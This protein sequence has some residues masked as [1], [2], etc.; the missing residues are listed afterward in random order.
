VRITPLSYH[1]RSLLVRAPTT[2]ASA[3]GVGL[4][5]FV[6]AAVLMLLGGLR[7]A[8]AVGGD[9]RRVIVLREGSESELTSQFEVGAAQAARSAPEVEAAAAEVVVTVTLER[10]DGGGVANVIL[11]GVDEASAGLRPERRVLFDVGGGSAP[12]VLVG[13]AIFGR[14]RGLTEYGKAD[15]GE[16]L[17]TVDVAGVFASQ[18]SATESELWADRDF[19]QRVA[20]RRGLYSS[21]LV[22]LRDA[23]D[24]AAYAARVAADPAA[25]LVAERERDYLDRQGDRLARFLL[26]IGALLGVCFSLAAAIGVTVTM[27]ASVARRRREIGTLRALGFTRSAVL[28]GFVVEALVIGGAGAAL[29]L[30]GALALAHE[31]FSL[32]N[33]ANWS[34]LVFE[35]ELS[36]SVV[37]AALAIALGAGV[38]G[39]LV[40]ALRAASVTPAQ[41]VRR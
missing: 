12:K 32:V 5:V 20:G 8:L 22:R 24:F 9:P 6:C 23:N 11:R 1:F 17:G 31:R 33:V 2:I 3:L 27:H 37:G 40:P 13:R 38:L 15:L 28:A 26:G 21:V 19:V 39:G 25:G 29:G 10:A 16:G 14:F 41:A 34:Q 35:L 30:G 7:H 18:G 36:G 4:V